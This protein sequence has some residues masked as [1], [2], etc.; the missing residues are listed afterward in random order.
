MQIADPTPEREAILFHQCIEQAKLADELGYHCIWEVEHHGLYE[1]SHSSAPEVVLAFIAAHTKRI[2]I[3]HGCTLF[4]HRY[5]HPIRVAERLAPPASL[6]PGRVKWGNEKSGT[7]VEKEAFAV[8]QN[9]IH[10]QW[11]EAV[12]MIPRMW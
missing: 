10:E 11:L 9:T 5:N 12:S 1:Y 3:G 6:R 4:P 8:Y 7:R 2:R